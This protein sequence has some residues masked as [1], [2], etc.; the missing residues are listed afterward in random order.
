MKQPAR[1]PKRYGRRTIPTR[2]RSK[3]QII[4]RKRVPLDVEL[5]EGND[6]V[7]P[8]DL[9]F[10]PIN[11]AVENDE[12]AAANEGDAVKKNAKKDVDGNNPSSSKKSTPSARVQGDKRQRR[13]SLVQSLEHAVKPVKPKNKFIFSLDDLSPKHQESTTSKACSRNQS[14][15]QVPTHS[16]QSNHTKASSGSATKKSAGKTNVTGASASTAKTKNTA[17][18]LP[19]SKFK[20]KSPKRRVV[21]SVERV[22]MADGL[23]MKTLRELPARGPPPGNITVRSKG[24]KEINDTGEIQVWQDDDEVSALTGVTKKR[25]LRDL[26]NQVN[27]DNGAALADITKKRALDDLGNQVKR[28]KEDGA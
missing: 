24:K 28:T 22:K 20:K 13:G 10:F 4:G 5:E 9:K 25:V 1:S 11:A 3:T 18:V 7:S 12:N 6:D 21:K 16:I 14:S 19:R 8:L 26:G 27:C 2:S 15:R 17:R 23:E